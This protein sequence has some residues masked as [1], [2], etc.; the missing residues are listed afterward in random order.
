MHPLHLPGSFFIII[1]ITFV[2]IH[3]PK[4]A[5]SADERYVKCNRT[6]ACGNIENIGYPFWDSDGPEYCGYPG[7]QLNCSDSTQEIRIGSATYNV[8]EI[9]NES[10]V[11]TVARTD[12]LDDLCPPS[13]INTTW[14]PDLF[15]FTRHT[16]V[17]N[18]YYHC[19]P[20][21]PPPA[22]LTPPTPI[23]NPENDEYFN[24]FTCNGYGNTPC[25][26]YLTRNLSEL[27]LPAHIAIN[28]LLGRCGDRVVL[29]A[30]QS[31]IQSL[32][33]SQNLSEE[34]LVDALEKGFG[35]QWN[36]NNSLCDQ[37]GGSGGL[38][39]YDKVS[40]KFSCYCTDRPYDTVCPTGQ[41]ITSL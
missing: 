24:H 29:V 6:F 5:S 19:L 39:G 37:C 15:E 33:T 8:L 21:P 13:L 1:I 25:G 9:D 26:Y 30:N 27:P 20:P 38:C 11:L 10:R 28:G 35:L 4:Y 36:A 41:F 40:N 14:N 17:I 2:L 12:Y 7:F 22:P 16:Q 34:T 3:A 18:L 23:P 31:E 32:E